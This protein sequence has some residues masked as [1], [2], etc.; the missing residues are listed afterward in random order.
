MKKL[1]YILLLLP[2]YLFGS[3]YYVATDG[4]DTTGDGSIG[5]PWET[6][7]KGF[8]ET[9][10]GDTLYIRGGTYYPTDD[11]TI[12]SVSGTYGDPVVYIGYPGETVIMDCK[13]FPE[14]GY[15]GGID[16]TYSEYLYFKDFT[17]RNVYQYN[18]IQNYGIES[19]YSANLTF[20]NIT[21]HNIGGRG[22][23][24]RS[25]H[26]TYPEAGNAF[27]ED[28]TRFIN[29]DTYNICDT[30]SNNPGNAG[31]GW[32]T[33]A[34]M[35][36]YF[37][38]EG[39]RAWYYSD[40]AI[41]PNGGLRV[42]KDCWV[43]ASNK[44]SEFGIEG[45]GIKTQSLFTAYSDSLY[46]AEWWDSSPLVIVEG[47][48][49]MFCPGAA[50]YWAL[51]ESDTTGNFRYYNNTAYKC[52][53]GFGS[54]LTG[55][56]SNLDSIGELYRNNLAYG[57]TKDTP[58]AT[59]ADVFISNL[60]YTE[61]HNTWDFAYGPGF[62]PTDTVTVTEADFIEND[63]TTLV[64]LFTASRDENNDLP[65]FPLRL[66]PTSDLINAGRVPPASDGVDY[67]VTYYGSAPD[68][69]A[70]QYNPNNIRPFG[71]IN[72]KA[73]IYNRKVIKF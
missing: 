23:W 72:K 3:T 57:S 33:I 71:T 26:F 66:A 48:L 30:L 49:A 61:S 47:C 35:G 40:D 24:M 52:G 55:N 29:C 39:C 5:N 25:G 46:F 14:E 58:F 6:V 44:Y 41:D 19:V 22:Y 1:I 21:V 12:D 45:N 4:D 13:N 34:Y 69:G 65:T 20:E 7:Q 54:G 18:T 67:T 59:P 68:I 53:R 37:Y 31:D 62:T 38:W 73:F 51:V 63:S 8:D 27:T 60:N 9:G 64:G 56:N 15:N 2:V 36:C 50:G 43:M 17:V 32:K 28:T 70:Y 11:Q 42:F 16:I 10:T